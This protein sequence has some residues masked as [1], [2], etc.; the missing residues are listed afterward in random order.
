MNR[1]DILSQKLPLEFDG[2]RADAFLITSPVNRY[3]YTGFNSSAGCVLV[4]K[5]AAYFLTDFRYTQAAKKQ[6][7][8][9]EVIQSAKMHE[10]I[11]KLLK[12]HKVKKFAIE[13]EFMTC[14]KLETLKSRLP[15]FKIV[16]NSKFDAVILSQRITKEK[17]EIDNIK[18]AQ[19][20]TEDAY[21]HILGYI[22]E[23]VCE[24]DLALEIEFFM[25]RN[26]AERIAFDL[27][28]ISGE[29]T[30]LPHGVPSRRKIQKGDFIT[31]DTGA[32]YNGYH[33]DMTRTVAFGSVSNEQREIYDIVLKAQLA[34]IEA[35]QEGKTCSEIDAAARDII[36]GYGYGDYFG[37]SAGHGVGLEIHEAPSVSTLNKLK[38]RQGM[39]ITVEPGIYL[40]EKFGVRIEDMLEVTANSC[41]N[42]TNV[43]KELLIL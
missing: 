26:G 9:M 32:V 5:T 30:A 25:K 35:V 18:I 13:S 21:N 31:M 40:P 3:Y 33:S 8:N 23:G 11:E 15:K 6:I 41:N 14:S 38:L 37:H 12:K 28:T 2:L 39:V 29:N 1:A 27:I 36:S 43:P 42:L 20:I 17:D 4:F 7:T 24:R 16:S 22:K 34:A 10:S 19:K